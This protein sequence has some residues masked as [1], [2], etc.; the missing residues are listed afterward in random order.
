MLEVVE[1]HAIVIYC[2]TGQSSLMTLWWCSL[3]TQVFLVWHD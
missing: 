2:V 3:S 1:D